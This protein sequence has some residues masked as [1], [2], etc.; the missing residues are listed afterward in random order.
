MDNGGHDN[1]PRLE[2]GERALLMFAVW[3]LDY[4]YEY[5]CSDI[6]GGDFQNYL[7]KH[8][9]KRVEVTEA[10]SDVEGVCSC[11]EMGTFPMDCS[12]YRGEV[13]KV[14]TDLKHGEG[15]D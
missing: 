3:V 5:H 8:L 6:D 1:D 2:P 4:W 10:C 14:L 12:Q 7:D 13:Q 11:D 15:L 9:L